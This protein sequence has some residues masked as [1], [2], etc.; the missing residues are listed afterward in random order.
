MSGCGGERARAVSNLSRSPGISL[1]S[2]LIIKVLSLTRFLFIFPL[3]V[4]FSP[5]VPPARSL[6]HFS[7]RKF[8]LDFFPLSV[9]L[10]IL[11]S[12]FR[13][14]LFGPPLPRFFLFLCLL[15]HFLDPSIDPAPVCA[16]VFSLQVS[17]P[18]PSCPA[19]FLGGPPPSLFLCILR[20]FISI[21][22]SSFYL[23]S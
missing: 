17:C 12:F 16:L 2:F 15:V 19:P 3:S 21:F 6:S 7:S 18:A 8:L 9:F 1:S 23:S 4:F 5:L 22:F 20:S 14:P 11:F 10:F 13:V